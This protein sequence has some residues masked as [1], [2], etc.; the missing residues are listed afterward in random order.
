[1]KRQ[2][3]I[4]TLV[5]VVL[6]SCKKDEETEPIGLPLVSWEVKEVDINYSGPYSDYLFLNEKNFFFLN[7]EVI[8]NIN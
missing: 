2:Y 7:K 4:F 3:I 5:L 8:N 6:I 1:M